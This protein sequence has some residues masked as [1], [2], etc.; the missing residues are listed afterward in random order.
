ML[1]SNWLKDNLLTT[2]VD[3]WDFARKLELAVYNIEL[4]EILVDYSNVEES[5]LARLQMQLKAIMTHKERENWRLVEPP[6][7]PNSGALVEMTHSIA[8]H[9]LGVWVGLDG[10]SIAHYLPELGIQFQT[11]WRAKAAG[12]RGLTFYEHV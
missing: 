6:A 1:L 7:K 4:P 11:I 10:G 9:H 5:K 2:F 8:P 12:W 3:C